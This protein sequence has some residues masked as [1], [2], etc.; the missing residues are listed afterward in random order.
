MIASS[1]INID[2]ISYWWDEEEPTTVESTP[3]TDEREFKFQVIHDVTSYNGHTNYVFTDDEGNLVANLRHRTRFFVMFRYTPAIITME[4]IE[5]EIGDTS[6][7]KRTD[8][9]VP[10]LCNK[11]TTVGSGETTLTVYPVGEGIDSEKFT[12]NIKIVVT[13]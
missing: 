10:T 11:F 8:P 5:F 4:D 13:R 9:T 7:I 1:D 12:F 2:T 3:T 6:V